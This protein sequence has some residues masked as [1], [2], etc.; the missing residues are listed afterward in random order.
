[1][2][3]VVLSVN[4]GP[5]NV[6]LG[7]LRGVMG[8]DLGAHMLKEEAAQLIKTTIRLDNKLTV[9]NAV[10]GTTAR[11]V[12][13]FA[14]FR[15]IDRT[16]E[17]LSPD[18]FTDPDMK[19]LMLFLANQPDLGAANRWLGRIR[20][21]PLKNSTAVNFSPS[22]H[23]ANIHS[24][25]G[26]TA[27]TGFL[28]FGSANAAQRAEYIK[29]VQGHVGWKFAGF[30]QAANGLGLKLPKWVSRHASAPGGYTEQMGAG[31]QSISILNAASYDKKLAG[32]FSDAVKT[33]AGAMETK[34]R[35]ILRGEAV[36]LGFAKVEHGG[37]ITL[38]G[39]KASSESQQ[40]FSPDG[41]D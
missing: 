36:N 15:A 32:R 10:K 39:Y 4:T 14:V 12:R 18:K 24:A 6:A 16:M 3:S 11:S 5:L 9:L 31:T 1:M 28:L 13:E 20:N 25:T 22:H 19:K 34:I 41:M 27:R 23:R 26:K 33:R 37:A 40:A 30:N 7:R 21:G 29:G 17:P 8:S 35:R 2:A 38:A